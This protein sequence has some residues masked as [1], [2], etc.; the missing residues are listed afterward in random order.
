MACRYERSDKGK[1][2]V[3]APNGSV[4]S[5]FSELMALPFIKDQDEAL[6]YYNHLQSFEDGKYLTNKQGEPRVFFSTGRAL[7]DGI[8]TVTQDF[9]TIFESI[10][11]NHPIF[12][13]GVIQADKVEEDYEGIGM[14][15]MKASYFPEQVF[16][17]SGSAFFQDSRMFKPIS[18][19]NRDARENSTV[20]V[21]MH[22][23]ARNLVS[24]KEV[25]NKAHGTKYYSG[26]NQTVYRG[27]QGKENADGTKRSAHNPNR[28]VAFASASEEVARAYSPEGVEP[29]AITIPKGS[30][31][32]VVNLYNSSLGLKALRAK[33]TSI[34]E[35]SNADVIELNTFDA[36]GKVTQYVIL[37]TEILKND[38]EER[39]PSEFEKGRTAGGKVLVEAT[40]YL[41]NY[42]KAIPP[43]PNDYIG[44]LAY[45]ARIMESL[46]DWA[47]EQGHF[48][49]QQDLLANYTSIGKGFEAEV[50]AP[51]G[52]QDG[53][54]YKVKRVL[55]PSP[56]PLDMLDSISMHNSFFPETG[57]ELVGVTNYD[58]VMEG[59]YMSGGGFRLILKQ[60]FIQ[61]ELTNDES[62]I[63]VA[64][65]EKGFTKSKFDSYDYGYINANDITSGNGN[66]ILSDEGNVF[67]IDPIIV[68]HANE[69]YQIE[70][71]ENMVKAKNQTPSKVFDSIVERLAQSG[72]SR[73]VY[74]SKDIMLEYLKNNNRETYE[75]LKTKSGIVYG[76][77]T[78][79]GDVYIYSDVSFNTNSEINEVSVA[80]DDNLVAV[81][82]ANTTIHEFGHLYNSWLK[83][84]NNDLYRRGLELVKDSKYVEEIK[85][86]PFYENLTEEQILE[87]AL[88]RAIGDRG[89]AL[90]EETTRSNFAHWLHELWKEISSVIGLSQLTAQELETITLEE[91]VDAALADMMGGSN[92][93]NQSQNY[94]Q[95]KVLKP[96][97]VFEG[98]T[99]QYAK[100]LEKAPYMGSR[101]GQDVEV[102]GFYVTQNE[103][104]FLLPNYEYGT[105]NLGNP[106]IIDVTDNLIGYKK[107]LSELYGNK[108]GAALNKALVEKGYDSIVTVNGENIGEVVILNTTKTKPV[109]SLES[110]KF[111]L[112]Q[113]AVKEGKWMKAPNGKKSNLSEDQWV[114]TRTDEFKKWFGDW[115]NKPSEASVVL[116]ENGEPREMYHGSEAYIKEF[117]GE[118]M[119]E[120]NDAYGSG[121]YFTTNKDEASGYGANVVSSFLN[122]KNPLPFRKEQKLTKRQIKQFLKAA[123]ELEDTLWNFG[124]LS[125]R[126]MDSVLNDAVEIFNNIEYDSLLKAL[127]N[128]SYDFYRGSEQEFSDKVKEILGY[129]AVEVTFED[130]GM[131]TKY[132]ILFNPNQIKSSEENSGNFSPNVNDIRL[133]AESIHIGLINPE[134]TTNPQ[135]VAFAQDL[136]DPLARLELKTTSTIDM[137]AFI[138]QVESDTAIDIDFSF[139]DNVIILDD[140]FGKLSEESNGT[141]AL[142]AITGMANEQG[143]T[144]VVEVSEENKDYFQNETSFEENEEGLFIHEPKGVSFKAFNEQEGEGYSAG[145]A[146]TRKEFRG[147]GLGV[148][149]YMTAFQTLG[150]PIY[151]GEVVSEAGHAMWGR[152]VN[153][154]VARSFPVGNETRYVLYKGDNIPQANQKSISQKIDEMIENG[155]IE[156]HCKI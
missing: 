10:N 52:E 146:F 31:V 8:N 94:S 51:V 99:M 45:G 121:Y 137:D 122:V 96:S 133:N 130:V 71:I 57:Y 128:I 140:T 124:D 134:N 4:S 114:L 78:K 34:I 129:D 17:S 9:D 38:R 132:Y 151:S 139:S 69:R 26:K 119:G 44:S 95:S 73:N 6:A 41:E 53:Y 20:G 89:D 109:E 63:D 33:E 27:I 98:V 150:K 43:S 68:N 42:E 24:G 82:L 135:I 102:A 156:A 87:E 147:Q 5:L 46:A 92:L 83:Q 55:F 103:A 116:D 49:D 14:A 16:V 7:P 112:K 113:E 81:T 145:F 131:N 155:E 21:L 76:F 101:F 148:N 138:S 22:S 104:N 59:S 117:R 80:V 153:L 108:T 152:L 142:V 50:F 111:R 93:N 11:K 91:Y 136:I 35:E 106:L 66:V 118:Y 126:S 28:K 120:G 127:N 36:N 149:M 110:K 25:S 64:L 125:S 74:T 79:E 154:G 32:E 75:V 77:T 84:N 58:P 100:N 60:P 107:D 3:Y 105:V 30:K 19:I 65:E 13:M 85:N 29:M 61:G 88:A 144:V 67:F 37:N 70:S 90:V 47:K 23:M 12:Q 143:Y 97:Q 141:S 40:S 1:I 72:L 18:Q 48:I 123:P 39:V 54:V 86:N 62:L 15:H 56:N 115:Q 2:T